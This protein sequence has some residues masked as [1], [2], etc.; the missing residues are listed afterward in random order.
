MAQRMAWLRKKLFEN[1]SLTLH[2][3]KTKKKLNPASKL[4]LNLSFK[5]VLRLK[6][7]TTFFPDSDIYTQHYL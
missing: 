4:S 3:E 2:F 6:Q 7:E 1:L 5:D